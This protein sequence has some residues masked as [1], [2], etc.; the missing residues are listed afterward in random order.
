MLKS[1]EISRSDSRAIQTDPRV[2]NNDPREA[3][4]VENLKHVQNLPWVAISRYAISKS[5]TRVCAE[6]LRVTLEFTMSYVRVHVYIYAGV[7]RHQWESRFHCNLRYVEELPRSDA[8]R[9]MVLR[10]LSNVSVT[11]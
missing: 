6:Y 8:V 4:L 3:T 2:A 9:Y 7:T 1:P 11:K 10:G 5:S